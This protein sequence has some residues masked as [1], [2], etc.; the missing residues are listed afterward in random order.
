MGSRTFPARKRRR[1]EGEAVD[2]RLRLRLAA[3]GLIVVGAVAALSIIVGKH[4]STVRG[5]RSS[6]TGDR[7]YFRAALSRATSSAAQSAIE[8]PA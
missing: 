1:G 2:R 4:P 8:V 5:V 6:P 3:L 7:A